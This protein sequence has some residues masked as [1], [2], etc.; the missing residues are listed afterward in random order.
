[1]GTSQQIIEECEEIASDV[2]DVDHLEDLSDEDIPVIAY[3]KRIFNDGFFLAA[4]NATKRLGTT[5]ELNSLDK[6]NNFICYAATGNDYVDY[7][8][9]MRKT[10]E[11]DLFYTCFPKLKDQDKQFEI[12]L[13]S[14]NR[15]SVKEILIY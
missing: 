11:P 4:L 2:Q 10:I 3:E 14:I 6:S 8:L 15:K 13:D 1:M 5:S 12:H 7:S 9:V